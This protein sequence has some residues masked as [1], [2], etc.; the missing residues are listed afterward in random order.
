MLRMWLIL[1]AAT[2][3]LCPATTRAEGDIAD[4]IGRTTWGAADSVQQRTQAEPEGLRL[5]TQDEPKRMQGERMF[6]PQQ[7]IVPAT[8]IGLGA[9][10]VA[11]G[12]LSEMKMDVRDAFQRGRGDHRKANV[13]TWV[14]L[15]SQLFTI[16]LGP[17]PKHSFA[18][19]MLVKATSYL[20]LYSTMPVVRACVRETRPDGHRGHAFPS[21][22]T[23]NAFMMAEQTRVERGWAW[24]MG[25]Y[26]VAAGVGVLQ[27]YND[28]C[29]VNDVLAG[30]GMG[31]LA[32]HAAYWLLPLERRWLGL[33]KRKK[34]DG[35]LVLLPTYDG[36]SRTVGI[37]LT[38]Q[39]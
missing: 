5:K 17:R 22:K 31:I 14:T 36:R 19:R 16:A 33:D 38:A 37:A 30:A 27:M 39:L 7:V 10:A 25:M 28:R 13:E 4:S 3:M 1:L 2:L 8:M 24:G 20:L 18:D 6:R 26:T 11:N 35:G 34:G 21:F 32:C 15:S 29:Y 12:R 23:A 9:V